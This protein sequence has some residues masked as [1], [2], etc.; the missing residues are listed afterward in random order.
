MTN[1]NDLIHQGTTD[2]AIPA[3]SLNAKIGVLTRRE[4]EARILKPMLDSMGA[5]FGPKKVLNIIQT[6]RFEF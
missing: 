3:D 5:T 1:Q 6:S 2:N 4:V